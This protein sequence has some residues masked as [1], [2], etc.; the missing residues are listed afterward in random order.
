MTRKER[1]AIARA[2]A[3]AEE[4]TTG[5]IAVRVIPD[6]TVD[7]F[8][9]AQRE[10]F[11]IGL[12]RHQHANA[13]LILVAPKARRFA[14]IGDRALHERVGEA[15]WHDVAAESRTFFARG[16]IVDGIIHALDRLGEALHGHFTESAP[17]MGPR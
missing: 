7:A 8:D 16:A 17:E 3:R 1:D 5:R 10:F 14:V 4:G 9:R 11:R 13:A 6:P 12:H 2:L 15:F